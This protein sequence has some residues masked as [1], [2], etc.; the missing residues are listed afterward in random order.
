[1][2]D[3]RVQLAEAKAAQKQ[4]TQMSELVASFKVAYDDYVVAQI[5]AGD[6]QTVEPPAT[7]TNLKPFAEENGFAFAETA[8]LSMLELRESTVGGTRSNT[9]G[10]TRNP[11]GNLLWVLIYTEGQ[12]KQYEPLATYDAEGN[13]YLVVKT[14]DEPRTVPKLEDLREEVVKA[15]KLEKASELALKRAEEIAVEAGPQ[16]LSLKDFL[17]GEPGVVVDET[18]AF[19][20]LTELSYSPATSRIPLQLSTP[21][22]L[23]SVGPDFMEAV[24]SLSPGKMGAALNHDHSVAYVFRIVQRMNTRSELQRDFLATGDFMHGFYGF[25]QV[26]QRQLNAALGQS[27]VGDSPLEWAPA[28]DE[29]DG[30]L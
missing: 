20:W 10:D 9:K 23:E 1:R 16:G 26:Y 25:N 5:D 7:L 22:P 19:S 24:F 27:L 21:E 2:E 11:R 13:G 30:E 28:E 17:A 14:A 15:W 12:V 8:D 3:I 6:D 4:L 18:D 29:P